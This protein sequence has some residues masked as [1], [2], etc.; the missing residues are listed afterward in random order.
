MAD[1]FLSYSRRDRAFVEYLRAALEAA[2]RSVWVDL[3]DIPPSAAWREEIYQ[4]I[5]GSDAVI[6]VLS[7]DYVASPVCREEVEYA[8][9]NQ[10]RLIPIVC[11]D[12][13]GQDVLSALAALNWIFFRQSDVFDQAMRQLLTALDTDLPYVRSGTRLLVRAKE[14]ESK[15]RNVSF[16]LRG[17]D[18]A[19]AEQWLATSGGKQPPPSQEQTQYIVASRRASTRRQRTTI[20]ALTAGIIITLVLSIISTT[21]YKITNDQN[22]ILRGHDIAGKANDA[23][24]NG[25]PDLGLLLAVAASKQHDDFDTRNALLNGLESNAYLDTVLIGKAA[26]D[27]GANAGRNDNYTNVAYSSDGK[28]LMVADTHNNAV[29]LWDASAHT[30]RLRVNISHQPPRQV[31][32]GAVSTTVTD[33]FTDAALS[34]DGRI[35][36]TKNDYSGIRLWNATTGS[37]LTTLTTAN[38]EDIPVTLASIKFS[39]NGEMLAWS[40]C[41]DTFCQSEQVVVWDVATQRVVHVLPL[42]GTSLAGLSVTLAFS[43]DSSLLATGI[44]DAL[45]R[46]LGGL[47]DIFA[48]KTGTL[49]NS[50]QLSA[51]GAGSASGNVRSL[52]FSPDGKLLA[53]AGNQDTD[54]NTGQ[55]LF[56][57]I[58]QRQ[59]VGTALHESDGNIVAAA[60][61]PDGRYLVT[62]MGSNAFGLRVWDMQQRIPA[63]PI[64]KGHTDFINTIAFSPD[65]RH[66]VSC[67]YDGQVLIWHL[68]PF[69][70]LSHLVSSFSEIAFSPDG[71][72]LATGSTNTITLWDVKS[73]AQVK[74]LVIPA[75]DR[76]NTSDDVSSLAFSPDGKLLASGDELA[77][78]VL[79]NVATGQPLGPPLR[80]HQVLLPGTI[81]NLVSDL[82]FSPNGA[83]LASSG[84]DGQTILWNVASQTVVHSFPGI[85][86]QLRQA[87]FSPD[88]RYLAVTGLGHDIVIW[89]V[90]EQSLARTIIS[91]GVWVRAVAFYP[92]QTATLAALDANG[93]ITTWDVHN[94]TTIGQPMT[95]SRVAPTLFTP[96]LTFDTSGTLLL[97]AHDLSLTIWDMS[98]IGQG[99]KYVRTI[100]PGNTL[101]NAVFSPDG[102]YLADATGGAIEV[103]Y[104]TVDGW[105]AA[106]CAIANRN[107]SQSEWQQFMPDRPYQQVC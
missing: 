7:P 17:K 70:P 56:W 106:A 20:G 29:M 85:F 80:G 3:R 68:A 98:Q 40:E 55:V 11:R 24:L 57:N 59:F 35:I 42:S 15:G 41:A 91:G 47:V 9:A 96:H 28:T 65:G 44:Y 8:L 25:Q 97:S 6:C 19:E 60:F 49:L 2:K 26:N 90:T 45:K 92:H 83:L 30:L 61:S 52:A 31:N 58:A 66:F 84:F 22:V 46:Q 103:R 69:T 33:D 39:P 87:A 78:I 86:A 75:A 89:D 51:G 64:L 63:S 50:I 62:G 101:W 104:A 100:V 32:D 54:G 21:L 105:R 76:N 27:T 18:L 4:A 107:L 81:Y 102:R 1:V 74:T 34:P 77:Q 71:Q 48:A 99:Q 38:T 67:A 37:L 94:G 73:G 79:W 23:L 53:I 12:V 14:W 72:L 10:K 95:D 88:G 93:M 43:P 5:A 36:A 82:V 13:R 16:T